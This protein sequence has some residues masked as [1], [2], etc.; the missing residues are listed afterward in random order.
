MDHA[1]A[2]WQLH[3]YARARHGFTNPTVDT[4]GTPNVDFDAS[5]D[6]H[7]WTAMTT[8]LGEVFG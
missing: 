4:L 6:R 3:V 7:S 5:A 8:L 1:G 2:D